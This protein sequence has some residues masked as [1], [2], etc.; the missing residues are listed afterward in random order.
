MIIISCDYL[1]LYTIEG[2][3]WLTQEIENIL[4]AKVEEG[5]LIPAGTPTLSQFSSKMM[6]CFKNISLHMKISQDCAR[7]KCLS[8]N[9]KL[10]LQNNISTYYSEVT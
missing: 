3:T 6:Y 7:S 4:N 2:N 1:N 10:L 9:L 5:L 8:R